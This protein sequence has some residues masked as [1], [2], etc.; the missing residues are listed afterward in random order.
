MKFRS[1]QNHS[2][3]HKTGRIIISLLI[4]IMLVF[5]T[6]AGELYIGVSTADI[7]PALPVALDG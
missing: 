5:D 1:V 6:Y 7:T 4:L 2:V 3:V